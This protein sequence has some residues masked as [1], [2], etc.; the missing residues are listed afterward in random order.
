MTEKSLH[1]KNISENLK[2]ING[3]IEKSVQKSGRSIND[4]TLIAV[5]KTVDTAHINAALSEGVAHIGENRVQ[6]YLEK[7]GDLLPCT[8]HMIGTLQTNKV[9]S[10]VGKVDLIQS[11]N[12]LKLAKEI[13][14][15][16][17][18]QNIIS[19]ILIEVNIGNEASK[20]GIDKTQT[21]ALVEEIAKLKGVFV[22]GLMTIAPLCEQKE[23][24]RVFFYNMMQLFIDIKG[25]KM[26]N[27]S[28]D[29]LSM[30]MSGDFD[31]A[32]EEGSNMIRIGSAIFGKRI[33]Y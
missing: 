29:F 16:S 9:K 4:I 11:V 31:I 1:D 12:S 30:G 21:E 18:K 24:N 14:D 19:D 8:H 26:D 10:I 7:R 5:T 6:E 28:M 23:K 20:T 32:L 27:I 22:K 3:Q 17:I 13:S 33:S 2:F 15:Q 25:K